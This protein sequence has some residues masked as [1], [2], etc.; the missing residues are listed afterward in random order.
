[1]LASSS[2]GLRVLQGTRSAGKSVLEWDWARLRTATYA[3]SAL[4]VIGTIESLRRIGYIPV[5][6]GDAANVRFD[7]P[8]IGGIWYRFSML[9]GVAALLVGAQASARRASLGVYTAGVLSLAIV[10]VYGPRF[11][12]L[13]PLGVSLVLWNRVRS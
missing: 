12:V 5:L 2:I 11:F 3:M 10:G 6:V 8:A 9:G 1:M 7:F 13:L 4:A